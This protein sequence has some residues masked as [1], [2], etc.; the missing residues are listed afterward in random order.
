MTSAG[1]P[2][3]MT[4][5]LEQQLSFIKELDKLKSISRRSYLINED[6]FER[7]AEHSW[8]IS[9]IA[10]L[11]AE[12]ANEPVDVDR[13]IKMML[14]HDVVEIDAGD[15]LVYDVKGR[16]D[17]VEKE[18]EAADR[19]FGL[20]PDDQGGELRSLWDEFEARETADSMYA[21]AIDRL[22]PIIHNYE[23]QGRSWQ[24]HN[25][26]REM[27]LTFNKHMKDGSDDLWQYVKNLFDVAVEKG[28]LQE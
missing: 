17:V 25:V 23:T 9:V 2:A 27:A 7:S 11:L 24:E 18:K 14:I 26:N 22:M 15:V 6:R 3:D 1:D 13:V 20:L 5:R 28:Y 21:A 10:M 19:L 8:H 12:Y 16:E 4:T